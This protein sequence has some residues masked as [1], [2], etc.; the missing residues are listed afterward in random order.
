M[1][2]EMH[3]RGFSE[4]LTSKRGPISGARRGAA[5]AWLTNPVRCS[6]VMPLDATA[7]HEVHLRGIS[8]ESQ[9]FCDVA[10]IISEDLVTVESVEYTVV[11][12][13]K[14]KMRTRQT[15]HLTLRIYQGA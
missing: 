11:E 7:Q 6:V 8:V 14:W 1:P 4:T 12:V 15:M 3:T 13:A 9:L 2:Y 10:D 5:V